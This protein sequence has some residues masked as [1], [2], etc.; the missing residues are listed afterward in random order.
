MTIRH[1][2]AAGVLAASAAGL[3]FI[4]GWEK[5]E[6]RA[7]ADPALGWA[8]PTICDGH[9]GPDV[10]KGLVANDPM[11]DAWLAKDAETSV[12]AVVRCT[13]NAKLYRHELDAL[14]SF[15]HNVGP[16]AFC[17]STMARLI[18]SGDYAAV[19]PQFDRWVYAGGKK[20]N[21]LVNRRAAER[22]LWERGDYGP[23][24]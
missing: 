16:T 24:R 5:R 19:G 10:R 20:L 12:K 3:A 14:V 2:V 22:N 18:Q 21:G 9:T 1:R 11:C 13:G 6:Y 4:T 17:K 15:I 7:Y 23:V 8:V